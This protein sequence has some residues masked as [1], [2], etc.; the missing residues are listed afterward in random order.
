VNIIDHWNCIF[1]DEQQLHP[2]LDAIW[3]NLT[4]PGKKGWKSITRKNACDTVS[5]TTEPIIW[6]WWLLYLFDSHVNLLKLTR[7]WNV[8]VSEGCQP[9]DPH[10]PCI[11]VNIRSACIFLVLRQP[12]VLGIQN[13]VASVEEWEFEAYF[14]YIYLPEIFLFIFGHEW[15]MKIKWEFPSWWRRA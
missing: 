6:R 15:W 2:H 3:Q 12:S 13:T 10:S 9:V 8:K 1:A 11:L 5:R 4:L 7:N 14:R